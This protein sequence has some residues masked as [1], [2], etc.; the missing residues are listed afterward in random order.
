MNCLTKWTEVNRWFLSILNSIF[1]Q[2]VPFKISFFFYDFGFFMLDLRYLLYNRTMF[3]TS[4]LLFGQRTTSKID[5][6]S[7]LY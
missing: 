7:I 4:I 6:S 3:H 1:V 2:K 5:I